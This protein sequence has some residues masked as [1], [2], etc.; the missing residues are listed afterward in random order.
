MAEEKFSVIIIGAGPAGSTAAYL[1]ALEGLD[2]LLIERGE[3]P[4][5]KNMYGG[6]MY[7]YALNRII[8]G[9]W[10]EAPIE[11]RVVTE[12][13]SFVT[14]ERTA[15]LNFQDA[16]WNKEPYHSFILLRAE[17]DAWL[18]GKA[19]EEGAILACGIRVDDVI[20][21][22]DRVI[23]VRAGDDEIFADVVIVADGGNSLITERAG[24]REKPQP[25]Q[26]ATGVKQIIELSQDLINQRF[27]I[28][29]DEGVANLFVGACTREVPGGGF[30][31]TNKNSISLG[32]VVNMAAV[33]QMKYK[34]GEL[35]EDFK[36]HPHI[37]PYIEGGQ[38]MEYSAHLVPEAG[39]NMMPRLFDA[40]ILVAGDAAGFVINL[41]Y[42]V[43]GMDLAIA[44]G[45]AAAKTILEARA[46][47]DYSR[48]GLSIYQDHLKN[49]VVLRDLEMYRQ[50]PH[51]LEN[52]RL[53]QT[54]PHLV[55]SMLG[56][57]F[58]VEGTKPEHIM[59]RALK[60]VKNAGV[61]ITN[62]AKDAWKGGRSL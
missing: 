14:P 39:Y 17:F 27:Q 7:S 50:A 26:V 24:L 53:Y 51:F 20:K 30:L 41:G 16:H 2:V 45:E 36:S 33:Q 57:M 1:L 44:S 46:K 62:L 6:R 59:G 18:A 31:Y 4:G 3:S 48:Q 25:A 5:C 23:G 38:V 9:F 52:S 47:E 40:G 21:E 29:S 42:L 28:A 10:E 37:A 11:R 55:T 61:G 35:L 32:L 43:R 58:T 15:T 22:G 49:N 8:P 60:Q 19:E 34:I 56:E 12:R 13:V 54:Y